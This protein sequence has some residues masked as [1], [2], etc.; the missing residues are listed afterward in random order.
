MQ[1]IRSYWA[2]WQSSVYSSFRGLVLTFKKLRT[3][4]RS[5]DTLSVKDAAYFQ[6]TEGITTIQYPHVSLPVPET[7]RY[8]LHNEIDDCIVC[9]KCV[10]ICPVNCITIEPIKSPEEFGR[11]SD[12]TPKRIYAA[13]FDIDMGKCCFCGLCTTVCPTECLTMTPEYDFSVYDIQEHNFSFADMTAQQIA[14]KKKVWEEHQMAKVAT[15]APATQPG[16]T[17]TKPKPLFKPR[18]KPTGES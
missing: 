1:S 16:E 12:G 18:I 14:E 2:N 10:K 15:T 3:S 5:A 4:I 11:T 17:S 6:N 8:K 13:K 7:G 9:D